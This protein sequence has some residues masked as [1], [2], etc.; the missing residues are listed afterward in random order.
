MSTTIDTRETWD[1]LTLLLIGRP[2]EGW[3]DI[4]E[5]I[6]RR[7]VERLAPHHPKEE[8]ES[9]AAGLSGRGEEDGTD[10]ERNSA[11]DGSIHN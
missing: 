2:R 3:E 4:Y 5:E 8:E 10:D 6:T 9:P 1:R 11:Y 7:E